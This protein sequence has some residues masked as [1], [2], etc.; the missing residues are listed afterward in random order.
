MKMRL[1]DSTDNRGLR[2]LIQVMPMPGWVRIAFAREPDFCHGLSVQGTR[3]QVIVGEQDGRLVGMGCRS[4]RR[5]YINGAATPFGYLSGLRALPESRQRHLLARGYRFLHDLHQDG[6]SPA[7]TTTIVEGNAAA[8]RI[9]TSR[10]AGLPDYL[11]HGRYTTHAIAVRRSRRPRTNRGQLEVLTG[12][13][14]DLGDLTE[15]I[16]REGARRHFF[17]VLNV[18]QFGTP[19]LRDLSPADFF[20]ACR[21]GRI[22]GTVAAWDQS[23]FKQNVVC[24]YTP[25]LQAT[26]PLISGALGI[27]GFPGLPPVGQPLRQLYAAFVCVQD[28]SPGTLSVLLQHV[29]Q[30]SQAEGAHLL[31][32][33]FHERDPLV[34]A[35]D[36]RFCLKYTARLYLACWKD[37]RPFCETLD[38]RVPYLEL[39][40]L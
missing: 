20:V 11:D 6:A 29:L 31:T 35:I 30:S 24:G 21:T 37:G 32:I 33:G 38:D 17:P 22:V 28:D 8:R 39:A 25:A 2:N 19:L 12:D 14:V 23:A 27:A 4:L 10:R 13:Q 26:R 40:T 3:N 34:R 36:G 16:N 1:A 9:L 7:Y 5:M 15:F 18:E